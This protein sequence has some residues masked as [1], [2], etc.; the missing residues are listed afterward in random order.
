AHVL[1]RLDGAAE[2]A[3]TAAIGRRLSLG[4][5]IQGLDGRGDQAEIIAY[6]GCVDDLRGDDGG[7]QP[8][9]E[10][11]EDGRLA[12]SPRAD[13]GGHDRASGRVGRG[14]GGEGPLEPLQGLL[15]LEDEAGAHGDTLGALR[16]ACRAQCSWQRERIPQ[17]PSAVF[18]TH[19]ARK[20][21]TS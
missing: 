14:E 3:S 4:G 2:T 10:L 15:L 6:D 8:R 17:L 16:I 9:L 7:R 5:V 11:P 21:S 19:P 12:C 13:D 18:P 20:K 1:P